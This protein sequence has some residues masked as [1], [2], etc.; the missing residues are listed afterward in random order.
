M[1]KTKRKGIWILAPLLLFPGSCLSSAPSQDV[2]ELIRTI[3]EQQQKIQSVAASFSQKKETSL[4][5]KPLLS[6]GL[7]KF[8]RPDRIHWNYLKPEPME[9]ALDGESIWV[10]TPGHSQAEQYSRARSLRFAQYLD[11]MTAVFQKTFAQLAEVYAIAYEGLETDHTHHFRL[12]PKEEKVQKFLSRLDLWID[13]ASGAILRLKIAETSGDRL[14]LEFKDL[15]INPS[16]TDDDLRVRIPPSV[17]VRQQ[18][19]P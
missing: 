13:K 14:S 18:G 16:L 7:V 1:P 8:K 3:D 2:P 6:S 4:A 5:R 11:P 15:Q 17:R 19:L 10:Y 9:V 12:L